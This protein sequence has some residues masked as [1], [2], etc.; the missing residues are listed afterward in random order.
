MASWGGLRP[1]CIHS[2]ISS[3]WG[4]WGPPAR[5][6][7]LARLT[8]HPGRVRESDGLVGDLKR[9]ARLHE[10]GK[11]VDAAHHAAAP[12]RSRTEVTGWSPHYFWSRYGSWGAPTKV[13]GALFGNWDGTGMPSRSLWPDP[14]RA[15]ILLVAIDFYRRL[16]GQAPVPPQTPEGAP[17]GIRNLQGTWYDP[18]VGVNLE[19]VVPDR[20]VATRQSRQQVGIDQLQGGT[21]LVADLQTSSAVSC[22]PRG[23]R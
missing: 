22:W 10:I 2:C 11:G 9:G 20:P 7:R 8:R 13:I 14:L 16:D 21:I 18:V 15:Q 19:S 5:G 3:I 6:R 12:L 1:P 4:F 17:E 23:P